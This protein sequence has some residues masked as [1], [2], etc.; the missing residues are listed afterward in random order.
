MASPV[1]KQVCI[2]KASI[3]DSVRIASNLYA[4]AKGRACQYGYVYT[5]GKVTRG[6]S[7]HRVFPITRITAA[8]RYKTLRL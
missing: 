5:W 8:V 6:N 4:H 2:T 7:G 1:S 3:A